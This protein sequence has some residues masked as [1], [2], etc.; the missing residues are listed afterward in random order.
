M[1]ASG[2]QPGKGSIDVRILKVYSCF[3]NNFYSKEHIK[4]RR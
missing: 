4:Q 3:F 1:A 2:L